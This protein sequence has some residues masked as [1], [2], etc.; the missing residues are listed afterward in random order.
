MLRYGTRS[1]GISQFYLHTP[2]TS[3][4]GMNHTCLCLPS[5]SCTLLQSGDHSGERQVWT[6]EWLSELGWVDPSQG[7]WQRNSRR[8]CWNAHHGHRARWTRID[9]AKYNISLG[10]GSGSSPK[11]PRLAGYFVEITT[12]VTR[13]VYTR[14]PGIERAYFV[15]CC[16]ENS[17]GCNK[18][19]SAEPSVNYAQGLLHERHDVMIWARESKQTFI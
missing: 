10:S 16:A 14:W 9:A 19:G 5:R 6:D 13:I 1:Q 17:Y 12:T 8:R 3:A 2:R 7:E 18:I 4:N 11:W 15:G